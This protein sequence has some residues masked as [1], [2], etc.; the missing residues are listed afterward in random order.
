MPLS[1][2]RHG[3]S[4]M[5]ARAPQNLDDRVDELLA[6][7]RAESGDFSNHQLSAGSEQLARPGVALGAERAGPEARRCQMNG[8]RVAVRIAG[9]LAEDPVAAASV[10]Q[11]D[12]RPQL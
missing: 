7:L 10:G 2:A 11:G 9:D 4:S 8:S 5:E 3:S 12:S 6:G 1:D